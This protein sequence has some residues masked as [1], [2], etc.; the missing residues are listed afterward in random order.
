MIDPDCGKNSTQQQPDRFVILSND[1]V[2]AIRHFSGILDT[3]H[4]MNGT[5]DLVGLNYSM[6]GGFWLERYVNRRKRSLQYIQLALS[7]YHNPL[8]H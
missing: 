4:Q 5:I 2:Y 8:M 6:K 1:S 3:L 7:Q